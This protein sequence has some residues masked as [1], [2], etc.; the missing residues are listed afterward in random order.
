[1]PPKSCLFVGLGHVLQSAI[2]DGKVQW[3]GK[4][5]ETLSKL[6]QVE[7]LYIKVEVFCL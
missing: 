7:I 5:T 4:E 2:L 3:G 1:M 6:T